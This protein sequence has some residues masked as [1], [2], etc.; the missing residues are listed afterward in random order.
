M[1]RP[2]GVTSPLALPQTAAALFPSVAF[3]SSKTAIRAVPVRAKRQLHFARFL[4]A[5]KADA[6]ISLAF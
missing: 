3:S 4:P 2:Q 5:L 1:S 6:A